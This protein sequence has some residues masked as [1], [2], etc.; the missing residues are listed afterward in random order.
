MTGKILRFALAL[1][2]CLLVAA[3]GQV[4]V[5]KS[6]SDV[7][8]M[9]MA[10]FAAAPGGAPAL[11]RQ[12]LEEDLVRSG[13]FSM[14]AG[15]AEFSLQGEAVLNGTTLSVRCEVYNTDTR[16]R[17]LAK[18]YQN[19]EPET[20]RLAHKAADD[21]ILALTGR[22]GMASARLLLV[23]NRTGTKEIYICD[24]D[25]RNLRQ[26]TRDQTISLAPKWAHDGEHFLYTSFRAQFP[27]VYR[28][29]LGS[30]DR[31]CIARYPGL[32]MSAAMS[33]DGREAA[34]ILSK[35]GNPDLYVM[36]LKTGRL[37]RLTNTPRAAEASPTW[38]PDGRQIAFVSDRAGSPQIYVMDRSGGEARRLTS[39]GSQNVDPDWG[40]NGYI[41]YSSFLDRQYQIY[42]MNP[43][44]MDIKR[45]TPEDADY[46]DPSWAP[47]GRHIACVRTVRY[48]SRIFI[49][50]TLGGSAVSLAL[51]AEK[52]DWFAPDW[53]K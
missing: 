52:G 25:G 7:S 6:M 37:T 51:E 32:N 3:P 10:G 36:E 34:L 24:A 23:G 12:V 20:R 14:V 4:R 35:D 48:Q 30:G 17:L 40:A 41:C 19:P 18:S 28:V 22:K 11:F 43:A 53:S 42:V 29:N 31:R 44:T 16:A 38:S 46:E 21:I 49:V 26:L 2:G 15:R 8:L 33:P 27:D 9:N 5:T 1:F 50:D 45:V 13:W 47:D 39:R